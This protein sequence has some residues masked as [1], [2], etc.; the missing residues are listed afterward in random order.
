MA[1]CLTH[2]ELE[3]LLADAMTPEAKA[4]AEA[5]VAAC[6][7]CRR[8][9]EARRADGRLFAELQ[10]AC[11]AEPASDQGDTRP[12][13][14]AD[15]HD[16]RRPPIA[17]PIDGY[18]IIREIGRG[19]MG[20]VYQAIQKGTKRTVALK[21]LLQG[22]HASARQRHRFEREID[23]V[24]GLQHPNIVTVYDSGV[25]QDGRLFYAMEYV[26]GHQVDVHLSG[27]E[28]SLEEILRLFQKICVAVNYAHQHG[29]IH[30]DLKPGNILIDADAE[31]HILDFGVAKAAGSH[32]R[33]GRPVTVTNE[34][35]GTLAYFSPEQAKGD[36]SLI[37]IRTDVYSLG[38][39]LYGMLT[40]KAPYPV[41]GDVGDVLKHIAE[42][43]PRKPSAVRRQINGELDTVVL[44]ALAK[45]KERRYQSAD[46]LAQD[47]EHILKGEPIEAK[48]DPGYVVLT[49]CRAIARKHAVA[50]SIV[51]VLFA[52]LVAESIAYPLF[53]K[54][55]RANAMFER[56]MI[57]SFPYSPRGTTLDHVRI[58]ALSDDTDVE[59]IARREDLRNVTVRAGKS[60][61]RLH[62]RL[63]EKLADAGAP[64]VRAV[65]WDITF[66]GETP[67]DADFVKGAQAL[68]AVGVDVIVAT[69]AWWAGGEGLPDLSRHIIPGVKWGCNLGSLNEQEPW[70][71][72]VAMQRGLRD[73]LPSLALSAVAACRL[74][75][76]D[77]SIR[78]HSDSASLDLLYH[79]PVR[80][81]LQTK[82][83]LGEPDHIKLT[84]V[85]D[86]EYTSGDL[87]PLGLQAGDTIGI[88]KIDVPQDTVLS[89]STIDYERVFSASND[90]LQ[91]WFGDMVVVIADMRRN[92]DRHRYT[93]GRSI[94]GC[95]SHAVAIEALLSQS[96]A[97]RGP[98]GP[99]SRA[100]ASASAVLGLITAFVARKR[101]TR[102]L[103]ILLAWA[104]LYGFVS[105]YLASEYQNL[106]NPLVPLSA[107][108]VAWYL[109]AAIDGMRTARTA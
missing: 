57:A 75:G 79:R 8:E 10:Q 101:R 60:L 107:L 109:S 90:Q 14:G 102:T 103:L 87:A 81:P 53:Y 52:V 12:L 16:S 71:L 66:R 40:G 78:L 82:E 6:D 47:V 104:L 105:G 9:L 29:V 84:S 91:R 2:A 22:P 23:L 61:R 5:H 74:P 24:A 88:L 85:A 68:R 96:S 18:E 38:L 69:K 73:P 98:P 108:A 59:A 55:T 94:S 51:V 37:D 63:M 35:I 97:L 42:T 72:Q 45:E 1:R 28:L 54:W 7:R 26:H 33:N 56:L 11:G 99:P 92:V 46:A 30:R 86:M 48:R 100:A 15:A 4:R 50:S 13:Q 3:E 49:N 93:D 32:V 62:G 17:E 41:D 70:Q 39:I 95:Y 21:V 80:A 43:E 89:S 67:F 44:K 36:P 58:L 77:V 27:K 25:T 64:R 106:W 83:W 34:L 76:A 65:V 31:P 20:V 19:G